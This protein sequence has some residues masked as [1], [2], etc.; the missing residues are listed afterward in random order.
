MKMKVLE[1]TISKS[2]KVTAAFD[3]GQDKL[4]MYLKCELNGQWCSFE[5]EIPNRS[6]EISERLISILSFVRRNSDRDLRIVCEPTGG[7][8]KKLLRIAASL[9][10]ERAYVNGEAVCK[11]KI[12]ENNSS[13]KSDIKD[14]RVISMVHEYGKCFMV[15]DF[16]DIYNRLRQLNEIYDHFRDNKKIAKCR[17]HHIIKKLFC[18]LSFKHDFIYQKTGRA[19]IELFDMDSHKILSSGQKKFE[20]TMKKAVPR[21][22]SKPLQRLWNDAITS[23]L[24]PLDVHE[25]QIFTV[26]LAMT[27]Q[28]FLMFEK[29]KD[30]IRE[31]IVRTYRELRLSDNSINEASHKVMSEFSMGRM[32]GETGPLDDFKSS[33]QLLKYAGLNLRERQSGSYKGINYLDASIRG[34]VTISPTQTQVDLHTTSYIYPV[35]LYNV[36]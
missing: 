24:S 16:S 8:E 5:D 25:R 3:V 22:R 36:E 28:E 32:L 27:W 33:R 1:E 12:M 30:I 2:E 9:R 23:E 19:L 34:I 20:K 26:E 29:N 14:P 15:R 7:Y 10:I 31:K 18:D 21:I 13:G 35:Q 6:K 17:L 11:L 4:N